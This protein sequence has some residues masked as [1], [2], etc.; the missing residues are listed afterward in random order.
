VPKK[1]HYFWVN[2]QI[3]IFQHLVSKLITNWKLFKYERNCSYNY[4]SNF[5]N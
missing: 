1:G 5:C 4:W 3:L 2:N